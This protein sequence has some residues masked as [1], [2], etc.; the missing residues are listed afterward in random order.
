M[1]ENIKNFIINM[2][3]VIAALIVTYV[4]YEMSGNHFIGRMLQG[5]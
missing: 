5:K 2:F 3:I 4:A 1:K